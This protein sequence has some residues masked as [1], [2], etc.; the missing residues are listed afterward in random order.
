MHV[1]MISERDILE[2]LVI[3]NDKIYVD[4][5]I[6]ILVTCKLVCERF[7]LLFW[8]LGSVSVSVSGM[9]NLHGI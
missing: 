6:L 4:L 9:M 2:K 1:F 8:V 7:G 3:V 5:M